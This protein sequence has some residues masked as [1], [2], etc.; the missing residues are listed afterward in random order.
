MVLASPQ[1]R[2]QVRALLEPHLPSVAVMGYNEVSKG[3]EVE[4]MGLVHVDVGGNGSD[5]TTQS[6]AGEP[7]G[8]LQGVMT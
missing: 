6:A 1:V 8:R 5:G 2:A 7:G 4:S 3:V